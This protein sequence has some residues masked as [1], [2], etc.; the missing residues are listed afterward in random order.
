VLLEFGAHPAKSLGHAGIVGDIERA[1]V[2]AAVM[3]APSTC[4]TVPS[5]NSACCMRATAS[6]N[7]ALR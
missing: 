5:A 2:H 3:R 6:P 4:V 1:G 7:S